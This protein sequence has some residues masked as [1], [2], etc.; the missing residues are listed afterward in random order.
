MKS[1]NRIINTSLIAFAAVGLSLPAYSAVTL[2]SYWTMGETGGSLAQDIVNADGALNNFSTS[3]GT[4]VLSATPSGIAGSTSYLHTDGTT[5]A[6]SRIAP[7]TSQVVPS[8]NWG[9]RVMV[10]HTV[11][12]TGYRTV[13]SL[14]SGSSALGIEVKDVGGVDYWQV[15]RMGAANL[16]PPTSVTVGAVNTWNNVALVKDG[17][18]LKFFINGVQQGPAFSQSTATTNGNFHI[19]YDTTAGLAANFIGDFDEMAFFTFDAG[20]FSTS[21][22]NVVPEPSAALLGGLGMLAL[23]RRRRA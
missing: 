15:N 21:D 1:K 2:K 16:I 9:V 13:L 7:G 6:G 20:Q 4:T 10:R 5:G 18:S 17:G 8:D 14:G 22:L 11:D 23:L 3:T 12:I 19:G